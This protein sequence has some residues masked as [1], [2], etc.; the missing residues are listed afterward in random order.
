MCARKAD[1]S[2][3]CWGEDPISAPMT[4]ANTVETAH[5]VSALANIRALA[6]ASYHTC[7][8]ASDGTIACAGR[9]DHGQL[10]DN[11]M[12]SRTSYAT[13]PLACP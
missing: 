8:I 4:F 12:T 3:W 1:G 5:S 2:T 9:N 11:T 13:V 6:L 10:G 7:V